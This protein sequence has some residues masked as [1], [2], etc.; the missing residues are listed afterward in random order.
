MEP[1]QRPPEH[2]G[3]VIVERKGHPV[4]CARA[5][6]RADDA[7]VFYDG[8]YSDVLEPDDPRVKD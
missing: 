2:I 3:H 4:W 6:L 8:D 7:R 5:D 1:Q